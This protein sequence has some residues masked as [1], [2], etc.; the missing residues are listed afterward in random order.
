MSDQRDDKI[1]LAVQRQVNEL[2]A[3]LPRYA[4]RAV[5]DEIDSAHASEG[6]KASLVRGA[7]VEHFNKLRPHKARR[8]FTTLFEPLLTDDLV[9][10]R[11]RD[12]VPALIQRVDMGG[13]W[14]ALSRLAFPQLAAETQKILDQMSHHHLLDK[15]LVSEPALMLRD[16][17]R[18]DAVAFLNSL[19][20]NRGALDQFLAMANEIALNDARS[21]TIHLSEKLRIDARMLA[22]LV[23]VL[24]HNERLIPSAENFKA[25]VAR[26]GPTPS[27]QET[28]LQ[29]IA[30]GTNELR[31]LIPELPKDHLIFSLPPLIALTNLHRYDVTLRYMREYG[32]EAGGG[33]VVE[34]L[35]AH[36][37]AACCTISDVLGAMFEVPR[38]QRLEAPTISLSKQ[39]R[40]LLTDALDRFERTL[41]ALNTIGLLSNR[42]SMLKI[43]EYWNETAKVLT[44]RITPVLA[45]RAAAAAMSRHGPTMDHEDLIW[46]LSYLWRWSKVI[47]DIGYASA[48]VLNLRS[49][50]VDDIQF[51]F[52]KAIKFDDLESL[53]GRMDH[54]VRLNQIL[55]CLEANLGPWISAVSHGMLKVARH[56]L[57]QGR[58]LGPDE[59]FIIDRYVEAVREELFRNRAWKSPELVE[60]LKLHDVRSKT[61]Q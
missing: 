53:D 5:I 34:A 20:K 49:R 43:K 38:D 17:M 22:F 31:Y 40:S 37:V 27:E 3:R 48:E 52:G 18:T 1:D 8:L 35:V 13:I 11:S 56:I 25:R 24:I 44:G 46:L 33:F 57:H 2:L 58:A 61:P 55:S 36:F 14:H 6:S 59:R 12:P 32:M 23:D 19:S 51:A 60:L 45:E 21:R 15:V 4:I 28:Y 47:A 39:V 9:L 16:R 30:T 50:I 26:I 10:M 42:R 7:L 54:F 29:H 41:T